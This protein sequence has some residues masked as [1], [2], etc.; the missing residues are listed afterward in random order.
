[1]INNDNA[2][3]IY[4]TQNQN[5]SHKNTLSLNININEEGL[6]IGSKRDIYESPSSNTNINFRTGAVNENEKR[7]GTLPPLA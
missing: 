2:Q 6:C 3:T 1:M 7:S 4:Y 5:Q